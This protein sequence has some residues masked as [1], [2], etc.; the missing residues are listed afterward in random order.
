VSVERR[1]G[2]DRRRRDIGPPRGIGDR[3]RSARQV[4][5]TVDAATALSIALKAVQLYAE[6]HPRPSQVT[7]DQV[8][9]MVGVS[10]ATVSRMVKA[11]QLKLNKFGKVSISEVD[12]ALQ[13][14]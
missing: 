3:R 6:T 2:A 10:R 5:G 14:D 9:E 11:G 1:S 13:G 7:Q 4:D 8:A 12:R